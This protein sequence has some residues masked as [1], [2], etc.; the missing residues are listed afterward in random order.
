MRQLEHPDVLN[1][2]TPGLI[3]LGDAGVH[4]LAAPDAA[5]EVE[6]VDKLDPVHR[7]EVAHM[8]P[9]PVLFFHLTLDA[10]E[11][12]GHV[13]RREFL[14]VF[15]K[16]LLGVREVAEFTQRRKA[17]RERGESA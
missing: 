16:E 8:R 3:V 13:G 15:L 12:P 4:A 1:L 7:L 10:L 14:V 2:R 5:G 9:D 6:T 11:D 17:G